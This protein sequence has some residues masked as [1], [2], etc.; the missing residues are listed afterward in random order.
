MQVWSGIHILGFNS[1]WSQS[2]WTLQLNHFQL[3]KSFHGLLGG[4]LGNH[5]LEHIPTFVN[6]TSICNKYMPILPHLHVNADKYFQYSL[7]CFGCKRISLAPRGYAVIWLHLFQ[8]W[9]HV[10]WLW[11][12]ISVHNKYLPMQASLRAKIC[13]TNFSS[14]QKCVPWNNSDIAKITQVMMRSTLIFS[15]FVIYWFLTLTSSF[16]Q[17]V[18]STHPD[19]TN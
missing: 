15:T 6:A 18:C 11:S 9:I 12:H 2:K 16:F 3:F 19:L 1:F 7:F 14:E 4:N 13:C 17:D 10:K 8:T 5:L